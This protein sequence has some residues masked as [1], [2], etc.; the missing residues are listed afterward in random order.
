MRRSKEQ[1][2][3]EAFSLFLSLHTRLIL[4]ADPWTWNPNNSALIAKSNKS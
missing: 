2:W 4:T 1:L 3:E